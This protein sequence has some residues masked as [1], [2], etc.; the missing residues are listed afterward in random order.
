MTGVGESCSSP[1]TYSYITKLTILSASPGFCLEIGNGAITS[2]T[3]PLRQQVEEICWKVRELLP[4]LQNGYNVVA[5]S[6]GALIGRGLVELCDDAPPVINFISMGGP[7]AG[8]A[9]FPTCLPEDL[10]CND[11]ANLLKSGVYTDYVQATS[12]PSG[13]TKFPND[14]DA[15]LAKCSFLPFLNNELPLKNSTY[16][17]RLTSLK[18][19]VLIMFEEDTIIV[20]KESSW[21]GFFPENYEGPVQLPWMTKLY[22]EDWIGLRELDETG[23]LKF[24]SVPGE[25][26]IISTLD[27]LRYVVPY[28]RGHG[29]A[30]ASPKHKA[31]LQRS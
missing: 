5:Q 15:Y 16:T 12:A 13:Y 14:I 29:M 31:A 20:P 3:T 24:I 2:W 27:S 18:N 26:L 30:T 23:R 8:V 10:L 7:Q 21:F 28:L 4:Q 22:T 1:I 19:L 9:S 17:Q 25:H 11:F 6:Q